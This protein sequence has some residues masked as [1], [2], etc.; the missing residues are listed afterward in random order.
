M[1]AS[2]RFQFA[3]KFSVAC[4]HKDCVAQQL[5]ALMKD[6]RLVSLGPARRLNSSGSRSLLIPYLSHARPR[7]GWITAN[8]QQS[9]Q[10]TSTQFF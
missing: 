5:L 4:D 1:A 6:Y 2:L 9:L 3:P 10:L 8:T 7:K